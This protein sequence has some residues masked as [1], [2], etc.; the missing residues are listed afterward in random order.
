[1]PALLEMALKDHSLNPKGS[2]SELTL[3]EGPYNTH[4]AKS[5]FFSKIWYGKEFV[6]F[7]MY[8]LGIPAKE[9]EVN[10]TRGP[11]DIMTQEM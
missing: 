11:A 8:G 6:T 10:V 2:F 3:Q 7:T 9:D 4:W 5:Y 1:M